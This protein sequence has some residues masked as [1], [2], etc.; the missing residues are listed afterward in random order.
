VLFALARRARNIPWNGCFGLGQIHNASVP[1]AE[2]SER[3]LA[4]FAEH[5]YVII[6]DLE[7]HPLLGPCG[8]RRGGGG[9]H[10]LENM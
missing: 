2:L 7:A 10:A 5:G 8:R 9:V 4:N 6:D 3:W 1:Y